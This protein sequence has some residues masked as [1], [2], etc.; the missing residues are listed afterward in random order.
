MC[1]LGASNERT[2]TA[3]PPTTLRTKGIYAVED[4]QDIEPIAPIQPGTI[5]IM[6]DSQSGRLGMA[7][8]REE[9]LRKV[10]IPTLRESTQRILALTNDSAADAVHYAELI[11]EDPGLSSAVLRLV[12][13][14][15]YS[16]RRRVVDI[17]DGCVLLGIRNLRSVCLSAALSEEMNAATSSSV[18][19]CWKY[20][21]GTGHIARCIAQHVCPESETEV[22]TAGLLH[23]VGII[24]F[25]TTEDIRFEPWIRSA[26]VDRPW[27]EAERE[28][29][30]FDHAALAE[31]IATR[32]KLSPSI[33]AILG[34]WESHATITNKETWS[35]AVASTLVQQHVSEF[36]HRPH[37]NADLET[38]RARF[39]ETWDAI[40]PSIES[41]VE[42][43]RI[44]A[45]L[46]GIR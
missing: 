33:R 34:G 22:S 13:S 7:P 12:N 5:V 36:T 14:A 42:D 27:S 31:G 1:E 18:R 20:S 2:G 4:P 41:W 35:I 29:F 40:E 46:A 9:V 25:L 43:A 6:I 21:L 30:G 32:W 19:Q 45:G 8:T 39:P 23:A 11:V 3:R 28:R 38:L 10:C 24:A 17:K 15:L 44:A 37:L 26:A 16:L